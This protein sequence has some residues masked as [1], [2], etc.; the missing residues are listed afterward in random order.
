MHKPTGTVPALPA[1]AGPNTSVDSLSLFC[2]G[3][4]A[5]L[6]LGRCWGQKSPCP[7]MD[8]STIYATENKMISQVHELQTMTALTYNQRD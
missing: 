5:H 3:V 6:V 4:S 1:D 8:E 7:S 2:R